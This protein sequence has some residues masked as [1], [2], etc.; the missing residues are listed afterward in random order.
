[1][2][3]AG[4]PATAG[5]DVSGGN[6]A[7]GEDM[8]RFD[9]LVRAG[10]ELTCRLRRSLP[11]RRPVTEEVMASLVL[12]SP[13]TPKVESTEATAA[14][15]APGAGSAGEEGDGVPRHEVALDAL[16]A[17][18]VRPCGIVGYV[19]SARELL[20]LDACTLVTTTTPGNLWTADDG[21]VAEDA[22][23]TLSAA[24]DE[25]Q[26]M[27]VY[28]RRLSRAERAR[29]RF[30]AQVRAE[31]IFG[32]ELEVAPMAASTAR[33]L[34]RC[35]RSAIAAG[36]DVPQYLTTG[37][38]TL[39]LWAQVQRFCANRVEDETESTKQSQQAEVEEELAAGLQREAASAATDTAAAALRE[40]AAAQLS[41]AAR[42]RKWVEDTG[43]VLND[44]EETYRSA[45][46]ALTQKAGAM[47]VEASETEDSAADKGAAAMSSM[48]Y[49][50]AVL[51][52]RRG[53]SAGRL[54]HA[55]LCWKHVA[56][57]TWT[58]TRGTV[59]GG[60]NFWLAGAQPVAVDGSMVGPSRPYEPPGLKD[61]KTVG[62][63][64]TGAAADKGGASVDGEKHPAAV[65]MPAPSAPALSPAEPPTAGK[66]AGA[67][68]EAEG[69]PGGG[70]E[71]RGGSL[72]A[73]EGAADAGDVDDAAAAE[74]TKEASPSS[75]PVPC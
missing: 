2:G 58:L 25:E 49:G 23:S 4:G 71:A 27:G 37:H 30:A 61:T 5:S 46:F 43:R 51:Q 31:D 34:A 54:L 56:E 47:S 32:F 42:R 14:A 75:L 40:R 41:L 52:T 74:A 50:D 66:R 18:R 68:S 38:D 65:A 26:P 1:M 53:E 16:P 13:K 45:A 6:N 44:R 70:T 7:S 69:A 55:A 62:A 17:L 9:E 20:H 29:R 12:P 19:W 72:A 3:G 39:R 15:G 21:F 48:Q 10:T 59:Q 11:G 8:A 28:I 60:T 64:A 63:D 24:G 67:L 22:P 33:L 57:R 36:S 35:L 73:D